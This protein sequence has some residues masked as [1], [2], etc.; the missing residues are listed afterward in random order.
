MRKNH[1]S[2]CAPSFLSTPDGPCLL[3]QW[4]THVL[5]QPGSAAGVGV[6]YRLETAVAGATVSFLWD[7]ECD[8]LFLREKT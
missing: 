8:G 2:V 6:L 1:V 7:A 3:V 4:L 5:Q